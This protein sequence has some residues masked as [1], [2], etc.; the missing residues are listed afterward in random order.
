MSLAI[1]KEHVRHKYTMQE[2]FEIVCATKRL[3]D[4]GVSKSTAS[5][6]AAGVYWQQLTSWLNQSEEL[7]QVMY[8]GITYPKQAKSL[9]GAKQN[10]GLIPWHMAVRAL[11]AGATIR[12]EE[13]ML[14]RYKLE[15]GRLVEYRR[16]L[17]T[18][19]WKPAPEISRTT[20]NFREWWWEVVE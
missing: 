12:Y 15:G 7:W 2:K 11:H 5:L 19:Q 1:K 13:S 4:S 6:R 20:I 9:P 8:P 10:A 14:Y 3:I 17:D 16:C 18:W